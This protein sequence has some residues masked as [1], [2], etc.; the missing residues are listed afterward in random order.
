MSKEEI[1]ADDIPLFLRRQ[2]ENDPTKRLLS[3]QSR[4]EREKELKA[5]IAE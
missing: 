2:Q 4:I 1:T 3:H 5:T